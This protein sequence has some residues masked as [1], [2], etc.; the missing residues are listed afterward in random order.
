[1]LPLG[2]CSTMK[3]LFDIRIQS[4]ESPLPE[5]A[6]PLLPQSLTR[7]RLSQEVV[8]PVVTMRRDAQ[9]FQSQQS[10]SSNRL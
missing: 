4:S 1:M 8:M 5:H 10:G 9:R 2:S 6:L 7:T 3:G